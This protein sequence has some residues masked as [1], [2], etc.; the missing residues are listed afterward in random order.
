MDMFVSADMGADTQLPVISHEGI[1]VISILLGIYLAGLLAMALYASHR[2][3]WTSSLDAFAMLRI[4]AAIADE[5]PFRYARNSRLVQVLD[6]TPGYIGEAEDGHADV[7]K[8]ALG[9]SRAL[10]MRALESYEDSGPEWQFWRR[11][12]RQKPVGQ[13]SKSVELGR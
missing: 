10:S 8:L 5:L 13:D 3:T 1:I 12:G 9:S 2:P 4:G 7:G 11:R 6:H